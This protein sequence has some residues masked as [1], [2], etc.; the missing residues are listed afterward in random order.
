MNIDDKTY[1]SQTQ[2]IMRERDHLRAVNQSQANSIG[3]LRQQVDNI[4]AEYDAYVADTKEEMRKLRR[5]AEAAERKA[6]DVNAILQVAARHVMDGLRAMKGDEQPGLAVVTETGRKIDTSTTA[7]R[8]L[9]D[10]MAEA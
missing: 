2:E 6:D 7:Q 1:I 8:A 10:T 5:A 9:R 3:L 4:T